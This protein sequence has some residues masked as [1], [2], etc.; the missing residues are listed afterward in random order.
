MLSALINALPVPIADGL[1][2]LKTRCV[3]LTYWLTPSQLL[4][5]MQ[6][7]QRDGFASLLFQGTALTPSSPVLDI[8]GHVGKFSD[9][10][11]AQ[12]PCRLE[13]F[14]P[15]P[16]YASHLRRKYWGRPNVTVHPYGLAAT[17]AQRTFY[18]RDDGTGEFVDGNPVEV[19]FKALD[20]VVASLPP[21]LDLVA[22]N[23]EGGEY[24][25][26]PLLVDRG[27]MPR[28]RRL[29]V[30]FHRLDANS[31]A[32]VEAIRARLQQTHKCVWSYAFVWECWELLSPK[33]TQTLPLS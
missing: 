19:N 5:P 24:E 2:A 20:A 32:R 16:E 18:A 15:M 4:T 31:A 25:L 28:I 14:E 8:G 23:I 13:I 30:Q 26:L 1:R 29:V 9:S 3:R 11:L 33:S 10:V 22:I 12:A 27:V 6:R 7:F 17:D 21:T